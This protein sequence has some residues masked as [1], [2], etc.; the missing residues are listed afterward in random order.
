MK[1]MIPLT[2]MV[3]V[4]CSAT[5][6]RA[7]ETKGGAQP[8]AVRKRTKTVIP[9][10]RL[11]GTI[12]EK[13]APED[14]PSTLAVVGRY[15]LTPTIFEMLEKTGRG[16]GGE[17]Q[18]TDAIADLLGKEVVYAFPFSG[19]RYD[20]GSKLGY[21]QATIDAAREDPEILAALGGRPL[22]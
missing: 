21:V 2:L 9:I 15:L 7:D 13:P 4:L 6:A 3:T 16:A 17:I 20:C 1:Q 12:T 5:P 22:I 10:F 11:S 19:K 18:L 8:A 14:A